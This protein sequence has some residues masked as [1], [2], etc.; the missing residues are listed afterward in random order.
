MWPAPRPSLGHH[1]GLGGRQA[2][3]AVSTGPAGAAQVTADAVE[4]TADAT[5]GGAT[6]RPL[7]SS[8]PASSNSTT[9]LQSRLHPCS[10]W[11]TITR[12]ALQSGAS[13]SGHR[14]W[15][16]HISSSGTALK[17]LSN[18]R[19]SRLFRTAK[20]PLFQTAMQ[21]PDRS[22]SSYAAHDRGEGAPELHGE[23]PT[24]LPASGNAGIE[25]STT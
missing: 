7:G 19:R 2:A 10:G 16:L 5:T 12:A 4:V 6:S 23:R 9:P 21:P 1:P 14:G 11:V 24:S 8:A 3:M 25:A 13:A 17:A 22:F 15:C 18:R 20:R